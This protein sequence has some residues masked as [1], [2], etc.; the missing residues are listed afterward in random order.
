MMIFILYKSED[1]MRAAP[2]QVYGLQYFSYYSKIIKRGIFQTRTDWHLMN[3]FVK[4][5]LKLNR[6]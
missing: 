4:K 1:P 3:R 5:M 6:A 2:F